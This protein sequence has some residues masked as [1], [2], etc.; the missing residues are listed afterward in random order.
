MSIELRWHT[1]FCSLVTHLFDPKA[2]DYDGISTL[3]AKDDSA[4]IETLL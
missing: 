3:S 1:F 4:V 2:L